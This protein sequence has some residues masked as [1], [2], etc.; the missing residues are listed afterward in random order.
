MS[1][2]ENQGDATSTLAN[3][4]A[5][6]LA[7]ECSL[8]DSDPEDPSLP[9]DPEVE[10]LSSSSGDEDNGNLTPMQLTVQPEASF[11]LKGGSS[12]FS[13]RSKSIFDCLEKAAGVSP[14]LGLG[15]GLRPER[16]SSLVQEKPTTPCLKERLVGPPSRDRATVHGLEDPMKDGVFA[17]PSPPPPLGS[18]GGRS[19]RG[20]VP[21]YLVHPE[22]W[23]RYSLEDVPETSDRK[24]SMVAQQYIQNLQQS[25]NSTETP[26][27]GEPFIPTFNQGHG[28]NSSPHKIVFSKP[29]RALAGEAGDEARDGG[30][31]KKMGL[32]HPDIE[33]E[34]EQ[35]SDPEERKRKRAEHDDGQGKPTEDN[36]EKPNLGFASFKK[37]NRK[38][39]RRSSQT[40]DD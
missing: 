4:D 34:E 16:S 13:N 8:S 23:T 37:I 25:K 9:F 11:S 28:C 1:E 2:G 36:Q 26:S 19:S 33:E 35:A 29:G 3:R 32:S 10:D 40:D 7:D 6:K 30:M 38:N 14:G 15:Q 12:S 20:G 17:R 24:N 39:V 21:D 22:R 5:I 31:R 27:P 18:R